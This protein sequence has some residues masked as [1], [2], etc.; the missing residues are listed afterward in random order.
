MPNDLRHYAVY[1]ATTGQHALRW[2]KPLDT[3]KEAAEQLRCEIGSGNAAMGFVVRTD[4]DAKEILHS[5]TQPKAARK[6]IERYEA[7][8]GMIGASEENAL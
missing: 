8:L 2:S 1:A 3:P 5:Y 6:A 4:G 7:L